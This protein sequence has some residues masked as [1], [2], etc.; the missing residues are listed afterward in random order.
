[1]LLTIRFQRNHIQQS[2]ALTGRII[3]SLRTSIIS[4]IPYRK[5]LSIVSVF[6]LCFRMKLSGH[7]SCLG[8]PCTLPSAELW[9]GLSTSKLPARSSTV[10]KKTA[11]RCWSWMLQTPLLN[12]NTEGKADGLASI[13]IDSIVQHPVLTGSFHILQKN[14]SALFHHF[15]KSTILISVQTYHKWPDRRYKNG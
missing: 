11:T 5:E 1:M 15:S 14:H 2:N 9:F 6:R 13:I 7:R 10:L 4:I 8:I 12:M 3:L